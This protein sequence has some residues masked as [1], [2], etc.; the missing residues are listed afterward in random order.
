MSHLTA[1]PFNKPSPFQFPQRTNT[2][3]S[4]AQLPTPA[5]TSVVGVQDAHVQ[6]YFDSPSV[7]PEAA[8]ARF[9][10]AASS[11]VYHSSGLRESRER[12]VQRSSRSFLVVL[13]PS[14]IP[15]DHGHLGHTLSSGPR[16]RLS[17]GLLMPLFPTMY[18]Q[19]TAI[20]REYN[21]P[22]TT[23]LCLY[24]HINENGIMATPRISD[25]SWQMVWSH[26]FDGTPAGPVHLPVC[27]K[28]EFDIDLRAARWYA[29]WMASSHREH[30]DVPMS[31]TP[32]AAP[33]IV[34]YREESRTTFADGDDQDNHS[35]ARPPA[36]HVPRKLSLVDRFDVMS[37][38][39]VP[40]SVARP[41]PDPLPSSQNLS[42][43]FQEDEPKTAKF[44]DLE[45][46]VNSWRA[47]AS[48]L[49][50]SAGHILL[51]S[52]I[53]PPLEE[54][55]IA[56][57]NHDDQLE[58]AEEEYRIED[59]SFSISSAGPDDYDPYSPLTWYYDPS[60]HMAHRAQGSV[61]L[62]PTECTSFGPSD[63]TLSPRQYEFDLDDF[64]HTPDIA[65]RMFE[66]VPPSPSVAT[67][68]GA[69][70]SYPSTP[71]SQY[72]APSVH[73]A[74]R[75]HYSRPTTPTTATSWGALES[76]PPSPTTPFYVRTPDAAERAF[77]LSAI[78]DAPWSLVWPYHD[79]IRPW[80]QVWPYHSHQV[81]ESSSPHAAWSMVW[82]YHATTAPAN[83][84]AVTSSGSISVTLPAAYPVFN[85]YPATYPRNLDEI[86]PA[87]TVDDSAS[88]EISTRLNSYPCLNIYPAVYPNLEIYPPVSGAWNSSIDFAVGISVRLAPGP[89]IYPQN[90]DE[91]YPAARNTTRRS[92]SSI[93]VRLGA[94]PS[95]YPQN[96]D[97]IYPAA[98][99]QRT[100]DG[101]SVRLGSGPSVYPQ[102]LD[103]IYPP[104]RDTMRR[105]TGSINVR[106]GAG[107]SIYPQS[108]HEIYPA[109]HGSSI[110]VKLGPS[111]YPQNLHEIYPVLSDSLRLSEPI[112]VALP[113]RY[114][115]FD[116][117]PAAYPWNLTQIY[118]SLTADNA[119][120][121]ISTRLD[122]YPCLNIY[123]AVYP[124]FDIYP[125]ISWAWSALVSSSGPINVRL[126]AG[127]AIYP[128]NLSEIYPASGSSVRTVAEISIRLAANYPMF[129]LYPAVYPHVVP[130]PTIQ[131]EMEESYSRV[132]YPY[133]DLYPAV[134]TVASRSSFVQRSDI[135]VVLPAAYPYLNIYPAVYPHVTPYPSMDG[136]MEAP[137]YS[138]DYPFFNL[139]PPVQKVKSGVQRRPISMALPYPVFDLYPAVYPHIE[140]YPPVE[141]KASYRS[142]I[143]IRQ[144]RYPIFNLYP[145][146]YPPVPYPAPE[147]EM[148][149]E[150][151]VVAESRYP[152]ITLYRAVYPHFD[153]YPELLTMSEPRPPRQSRFTRSD[154]HAL[155]K[156][157]TVTHRELHLAVFPQ[158]SAVLTPS[159]EQPHPTKTHL[160]LHLEVFASG[161]D[162]VTPSGTFRPAVVV[163]V[164]VLPSPR[165]A[166]RLRSGAHATAR[167]VIVESLNFDGPP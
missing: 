14:S 56:T 119:W 35:V 81:P 19:L 63:Y 127:D 147:C 90:L 156:N 118:P 136:E 2:M 74:D 75:G 137:A 100:T 155:L 87:V 97:E 83:I 134:G 98:T 163:A 22:S 93:N 126:A 158:G 16:N 165:V 44:N 72:R 124:N 68:W 47:S 55:P 59:Y 150:L 48:V 123:P 102:N 109:V 73:L 161:V 7:A 160:E 146:V 133:F 128:L 166:T 20:A 33:S 92:T 107:P 108:L 64:V 26:V 43:I 65:H 46:R 138:V 130:Y 101:I 37:A 3:D 142:P 28:V 77:D 62:T 144:S 34:H 132:V 67:S 57:T 71:I 131:G 86:Y 113:S 40:R 78:A 11:I 52:A 112:N 61:C 36:R 24:L 94:G 38:R 23:G 151:Q 25:D 135:S 51:A 32:S 18:G 79:T 13:P 157:A 49:P 89:S 21:F 122:A 148:Q 84:V 42:P 53:S 76:Y 91:I 159:G 111:V 8:G 139:Y 95:I 116:L 60:V 164:E 41:Q 153:L 125:P 12:T 88:S 45:N 82:P 50:E 69:P 15:Q 54:S 9:R 129:D 31:V 152:F 106:L 17:Q 27:G 70:L 39:S 120:T 96:L 4:N 103:E 154:L 143:V 162:V 66:D 110:S 104:T 117:Y 167:I 1:S 105:S 58:P 10:R 149:D 140:P 80:G 30:V 115:F 121:E 114:P 6:E 85:L 145:A 5:S 99:T 141:R 29:A